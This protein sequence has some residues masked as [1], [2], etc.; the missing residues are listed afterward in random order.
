M[1]DTL[2]TWCCDSVPCYLSL[3]KPHPI[4]QT[5]GSNPYEVAKAV[6]QCRMLSGRYRVNNLAGK[7]SVNGDIYCPAS[8]CNQVPETLEH[9]LLLCP[10]YSSSRLKVIQKIDLIKNQ[11]VIHLIRTIL[12]GSQRTVMQL[13]LDASVLPQT[14]LLVQ[15]LGESVLAP[16]FGFTRTWCYT[17]HT[18]RLK[19]LRNQF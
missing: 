9:L 8:S 2:T 10:A 19:S 16:I 14:I 13:L 15:N 18:D 5:P 7:W 11:P 12:S 6:I 17:V 1:L 3:V 4:W